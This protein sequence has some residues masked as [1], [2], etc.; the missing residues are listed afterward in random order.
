MLSRIRVW[1]VLIAQVLV[2]AAFVTILALLIHFPDVSR[3]ADPPPNGTG[4]MLFVFMSI[5]LVG[6]SRLYPRVRTHPAVATA[7][8]V[9]LWLVMLYGFVFVWINTF[10]E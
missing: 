9:L 1:H 10:G 8:T 3:R 7:I 6:L 4:L 5:A 2:G